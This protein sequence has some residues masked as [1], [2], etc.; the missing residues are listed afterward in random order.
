MSR[1]QCSFLS[2]TEAKSATNGI[3]HEWLDSRVSFKCHQQHT[4]RYSAKIRSKGIT[5]GRG[6]IFCVVAPSTGAETF[7]SKRL[8]VLSGATLIEAAYSCFED[9]EDNV[10]TNEQVR[11]TFHANVSAITLFKSETPKHI[12]RYIVSLGNEENESGSIISHIDKM[13]S[14]LSFEAAWK[15][16]KKQEKI[17]ARNKEGKLIGLTG[18]KREWVLRTTPFSSLVVYEE[19][20]TFYN[21]MVSRGAWQDRR[22]LRTVV[23]GL[24]KCTT[25]FLL[26]LGV[27]AGGGRPD[28]SDGFEDR[29]LCRL[30]FAIVARIRISAIISVFKQAPIRY[31]PSDVKTCFNICGRKLETQTKSHLQ[32]I[33]RHQRT[34]VQLLGDPPIEGT[35]LDFLVLEGYIGVF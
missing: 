7:E 33:L 6:N 14:L 29:S 30:R 20:L 15:S 9:S 31:N 4:H 25:H 21:M 8:A 18:P 16:Y 5:K 28:F 17:R 26:E 34:Q 3:G 23:I 13:R 2:K 32:G 1:F 19:A 22:T 12:M 27:G 10:D 11:N 35:R 24:V